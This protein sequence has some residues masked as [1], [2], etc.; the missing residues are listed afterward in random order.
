ME[1]EVGRW[2]RRSR[3]W[4]CM[5]DGWTEKVGIRSRSGKRAGGDANPYV[6]TLTRDI[7]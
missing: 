7:R 3:S 4:C 1:K 5:M 6:L 2:D